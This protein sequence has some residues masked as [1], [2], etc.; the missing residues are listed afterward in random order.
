MRLTGLP[1]FDWIR[2]NTHVPALD[3]GCEDGKV[4]QGWELE[5]Y[6]VRCDIDRWNHPNFVQCDAQELPFRDD[7]FR[8]AVLGEILEHVRYPEKVIREAMRVSRRVVISTPLENDWDSNAL[9]H[10][11]T[12]Q[13]ITK[14]YGSLDNFYHS[15]KQRNANLL[16]KVSDL[17]EPHSFHIREWSMDSFRELMERTVKDGWIFSMEE[18]KIGNFAFILCI[19]KKDENQ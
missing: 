7:Q 18:R 15:E 9:P 4:F 19:M 13:D 3:I 1:R 17:K 12:M 8:T 11:N 14:K 10:T 6:V 16:E 5:R 2:A